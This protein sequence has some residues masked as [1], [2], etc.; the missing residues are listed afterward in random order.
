MAVVETVINNRVLE[1]TINRPE[2]RNAINQEVATL[3][4]EALHDADSDKSVSAIIIT[5]AGDKA[6]SAGAD[7]KAL[8]RG[9]DTSAEGHPEWG[10]AGITKQA[11]SIPII[12]AVNGFALGG[13]TEIVLVS[14]LAIAT[15]HAVFGLPE[16]SRGIFA[17]GGGAFRLP[18]IIPEKIAAEVLY[19]GRTLNAHEAA[20]YGLVNKVVPATDLLPA[21]RE[22]A[23]KIASNAPLSIR[24]TKKLAR[25]IVNG[26]FNDELALWA[27]NDYSTQE[28]IKSEDAHEGTLA[29]AEKRDPVWKGK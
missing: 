1:I 10:F 4:G 13:G 21:A 28:I 29:F 24:A 8:S 6:F 5:G 18:K 7:L 14:D 20:D 22:L 17:G 11:I 19:A 23:A 2:S 12:A 27:Q 26:Q 16:I 9:E 25:R 3:I 15:D